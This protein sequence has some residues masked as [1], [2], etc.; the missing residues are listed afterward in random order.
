MSSV[1]TVGALEHE[2]HLCKMVRFCLVSCNVVLHQGIGVGCKIRRD[3][4]LDGKAAGFIA[5]L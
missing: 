4:H 5:Y 1:S 2:G 3:V